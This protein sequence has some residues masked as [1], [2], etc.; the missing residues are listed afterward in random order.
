MPH[1]YLAKDGL[2]ATF[3]SLSHMGGGGHPGVEGQGVQ[4]G[5]DCGLDSRAAA[6]LR[7]VEASPQSSTTSLNTTKIHISFNIHQD[8]Y[9]I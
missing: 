5:G 7:V 2:F 6:P 8:T 9:F 4:S 3:F 1:L